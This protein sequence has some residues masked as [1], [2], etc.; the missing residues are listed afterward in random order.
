MASQR[1]NSGDRSAS[2][3][4]TQV[5]SPMYLKK[6]IDYYRTQE[7]R[8][9]QS[10]IQLSNLVDVGNTIAITSIISS[11][12][13]GLIGLAS[14]IWVRY[15]DRE[16]EK[17]IRLYEHDLMRIEMVRNRRVDSYAGIMRILQN[18][19]DY[20]TE[21]TATLFRETGIQIRL[22]GSDEV[23][24]LF[25]A[26]L[27]LMPTSYGPDKNDEQDAVVLAAAN[28]ARN[29]MADEVQGRVVTR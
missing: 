21:P 2:S 29:R 26:W 8:C 7:C 3:V 28:R 25:L 15:K 23:L 12:I 16:H 27:D 6:Y 11:G 10:R 13:L 22:W 24:D 4:C 20:N 14:P 19:K 5:D 1:E 18:P 17:E 9:L